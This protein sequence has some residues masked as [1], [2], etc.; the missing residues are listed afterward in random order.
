[1]GE[2]DCQKLPVS[3][4]P[5][6]KLPANISIRAFPVTRRGET[7]NLIK[8]TTSNIIISNQ[9]IATQCK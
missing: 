6:P 1:L 3:T 8:G 5:N 9:P 4:A 7:A 2:P